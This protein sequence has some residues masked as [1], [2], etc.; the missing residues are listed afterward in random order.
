MPRSQLDIRVWGPNAWGTLH[1][2]AHSLP[3]TLSDAQQKDFVDFVHL[4][5]KH[6]PCHKCRRHYTS[7]METHL[8]SADTRTR[9][10]AVALLHGLHNDVNRRLGK[11]EMSLEED[12][13][14]HVRTRR[15]PPPPSP[16]VPCV[17]AVAV[18]AAVVVLAVDR[19]ADFPPARGIPSCSVLPAPLPA[20]SA[21]ALRMASWRPAPRLA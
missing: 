11:P 14:R 8:P 9:D 1:A 19:P 16:V 4:F 7:F 12:R 18:V 17:A 2:M 20:L 13:R 5:G 6:L 21:D 3:E 15:P 10:G